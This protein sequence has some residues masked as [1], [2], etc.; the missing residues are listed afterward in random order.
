MAPPRPL[1][2]RVIDTRRLLDDGPKDAWVAT[3]SASGEAH[4]VPLSFAWD[5]ERITL[6]TE[7][8]SATGR[9]LA[10][11]HRA[12]LGFGHTRDV[13]LVDAV[14][15]RTWSVAEAPDGVAEGY[16]AQVDWDPRTAA[17]TFVF[18]DLRPVRI[19]A[20]REENEIAGRTVLRDGAWL[21]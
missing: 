1:A 4:L 12:R 5:G 6:A 8:S 2:Q 9:N 15:E 20:W 7:A 14:V 3:A 11:S 17:G 10:A 13:V 19:Q 18:L 16:A 21:A